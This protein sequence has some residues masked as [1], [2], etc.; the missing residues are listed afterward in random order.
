MKKFINDRA[1][2]VCESLAA[3]GRRPGVAV[4]EQYDVLV[5]TDIAS[6][7]VAVVS[8]GGT[9]HEPAH[10]G[11]VG[12]GM[13]TAAVAGPIFTSPSVHAILAGLH[14]VA[15]PAGILLIVKNYTGDRLNFGIAAQMLRAEDIPVEMVVIADDVAICSTGDH[16][17]RRGIAG[18]ILVH[19]IA[20]AASEAGAALG[21]VAELARRA[22][23]T[24]R[25]MGVALDSCTLPGAEAPVRPLGRTELEWGLG[26]HGEAGVERG[27]VIPANAV[28]DRLMSKMLADIAP[29][30]PMRL[31]LL[32]NNL[33]ATPPIEL[34]VITRAALEWLEKGGHIVDRALSGTFLMALDTPGMSLSLLPIDEALLRYLDA[35]TTAPAWPRSTGHLTPLTLLPVVTEQQ[36]ENGE[37][38]APDSLMRR[39][40]E[41]ICRI[42]I[43]S[44]KELTQLD[45]QVGDGDLGLSLARGSQALLAALDSLPAMP[46]AALRRISGILRRVIGG[47][48]GPLYAAGLL[49]ASNALTEQPSTRDWAVAFNSGIAAIA[50]LGGAQLGDST[51]LDALIPAAEAFAEEAGDTAARL[52]AAV[53]A[54]AAGAHRTIDSTARLGRANDL[55]ERSVAPLTM[56][57]HSWT[58]YRRKPSRRAVVA[59]LLL[60][61]FRYDDFWR[62]HGLH[63]RLDIARGQRAHNG[64]DQHIRC[65]HGRQLLG[66]GTGCHCQSSDNNREFPAGYEG[67]SRTETARAGD[68]YTLRGPDTGCHF[69]GRGDKSEDE[70]P[71]KHWRNGRGVSVQPEGHK[72]D[73]RKKVPQWCQNTRGI[74]RC[75]T[76]Y[77]DAKQK[78]SHCC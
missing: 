58:F 3:Q 76:G 49:G 44:E 32:V 10:A 23:A 21:E 56:N 59:A 22:A 14:A 12:V 35:P 77:R 16:A 62:R 47:T 54:A 13:L 39:G 45:S 48:S 42:L 51:M 68:T 52:D 71:A 11:Y 1:G 60:T 38:L 73:R 27:D 18:T 34:D 19:K 4:L 63:Q 36:T 69:A 7:H 66:D 2:L 40:I 20:G 26:I 65:G 33:G 37:P 61:R 78:G 53:E 67:R 75:S 28:V 25:T 43:A 15:A 31:A 70:R 24:V 72:E 64:H 41:G 8:G 17:G 57:S 30:E 46:N 6:D 74:V 9:G 5:R 29:S 50:E 55:G